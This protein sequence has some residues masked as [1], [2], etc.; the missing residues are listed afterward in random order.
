MRE[1]KTDFS[2]ENFIGLHLAG[3]NTKK[4]VLVILARKSSLDPIY[5]KALYDG[6]GS[7]RGHF[8]DERLID[9]LKKET[10]SKN[11]VV[12]CPISS[13]P[14]VRCVRHSCPGVMRCEDIDVAYMLS[15]LN[16]QQEQNRTRR[17]RPLNPQNQRLWD[18]LFPSDDLLGKMEPS[19]SANLAPLLVRAQTLQRRFNEGENPLRLIET[20]ILR[21]LSKLSQIYDWPLEWV[22]NYRNFEKGKS[23]REKILDSIILKNKLK[24]SPL[25]IKNKKIAS[26]VEIFH[27]FICAWVGYLMAEEKTEKVPKK[28]PIEDQWVFLPKT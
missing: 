23:V 18:I 7:V 26:S 28:I 20:H 6:I 25:E 27:A 19:Y 2:E 13:P 22:K 17:L 11:I 4:T 24:I 8:S 16:S 12:D 3:A 1:A 21:T 5:V 10:R 14:C 15:V 9:I